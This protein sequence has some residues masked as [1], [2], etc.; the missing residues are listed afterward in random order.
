MSEDTQKILIPGLKWVL[1]DGPIRISYHITDA[2]KT[3]I[4][5]TLRK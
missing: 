3:W 5:L 2:W 4:I 1:L